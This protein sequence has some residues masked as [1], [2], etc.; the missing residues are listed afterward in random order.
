MAVNRDP[1]TT[2]TQGSKQVYYGILL[3]NNAFTNNNK[4]QS[5]TRLKFTHWTFEGQ[6]ISAWEPKKAHPCHCPFTSPL[7]KLNPLSYGPICCSVATTYC[8]AVMPLDEWTPGDLASCAFT[9]EHLRRV[10]QLFDVCKCLPCMDPLLFPK[11][12]NCPVCPGFETE[13][14]CGRGNYALLVLEQTSW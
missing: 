7:T 13:G 10:L 14:S 3:S 4:K 11:R 1:C 8:V 2:Y 5:L 9:T 6:N 12:G